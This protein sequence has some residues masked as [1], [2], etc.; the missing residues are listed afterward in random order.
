MSNTKIWIGSVLVVAAAVAVV[1]LRGH[2]DAQAA[3]VQKGPRELV[4]PAKVEAV[5]ERIDLAFEQTGRVVEVLVKEGDR[6]AKGQVVARLD[7]R[8]P[9][10]RVAKAEASL[11]AAQARRDATLHGARADE[12][13][14]AEA[15]AAAAR[16]Q[17][18]ER[19]L[20]HGR[21][22]TLLAQA[23]IS[24]AEAD[25]AESSA[26][27]ATGQAGA[28]E[29]RL[30]LLRKGTREED[31]R[32][33]AAAVAEAAAE[34]E[35]ARAVLAQTELHAPEAGTIL[36]RSVEPGEQVILLPPTVVVSLAD[37]DHLQLR[38]EVDEADIAVV[39]LGQR[40]YA[41]AETFGERRVPGHVERVM[42][43]LGRKRLVTDDPRA[44]VDTRVL[45]VLFVPDAPQPA[46][47]LGLRMDVHLEGQASGSVATN[48]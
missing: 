27:S 18:H 48:P 11:L 33:A 8:L 42:K 45:E 26:A 13:R 34:L 6:V 19:A 24:T 22:R 38:A 39:A 7:D 4:A 9:R 41:T 5:N 47:P 40:G 37:L 29:A 3:E 23:A 16:A 36:R 12:I 14:Q 15:E 10:A 1:A 21:A 32:E 28:A 20:A 44:R 30:A 2:A 25:G 43:E 46:L 17:A 31:K 35:E